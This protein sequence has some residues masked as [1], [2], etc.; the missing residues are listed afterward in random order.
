MKIDR[1]YFRSLAI[2]GAGLL[3]S[4]SVPAALSEKAGPID[5][6]TTKPE[7]IS[8]SYNLGPTGALGWMHVAGGMTEQSRQILITAV[9]E[10]S[11]ADGLLE[12][13]DVVQG[14]FGQLFTSDAR[15]AFGHAIG[16]M[17]CCR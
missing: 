15:R 3:M 16:A 5:L 6:T 12:V 10:T 9:E 11:P 2:W 4:A 1:S 13:G 14:V 17:A 7:T 8:N